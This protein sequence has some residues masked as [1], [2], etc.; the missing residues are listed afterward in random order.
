MLN[1]VSKKTGVAFQ[2]SHFLYFPSLT[3][4]FLYFFPI[5]I[6][7]TENKVNKAPQLPLYLLYHLSHL[8]VSFKFDSSLRTLWKLHHPLITRLSLWQQ[9]AIKIRSEKPQFAVNWVLACCRNTINWTHTHTHS[10]TCHRCCRML[11]VVAT[12]M[13][14]RTEPNTS[15][16]H[17]TA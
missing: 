5:E 6:K 9:R 12:K 8:L 14:Q 7:L 15:L 2:Y 16:K 11:H 17:T 4:N 10:Q 13:H 3:P 1:I